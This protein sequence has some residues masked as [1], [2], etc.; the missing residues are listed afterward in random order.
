MKRFQRHRPLPRLS[1]GVWGLL[2]VLLVLLGVAAPLLTN[3]RAQT[4]PPAGRPVVVV[5]IRDEIDLGLAPFLARAL[6]SAQQQNARAVVL[7]ISTPGGRLDAVLQM[8]ASL[9]NSPVRTVAFVNRE[10]FSAGALIAI[11]AQ[12]IYLA[13]G[14]V[15]GA[16][17]PVTGAGVAADPKT[18]SAV[19]STFRATAELRGRDPTVAEAMVDPAIAIPGLVS[20]GQLLTLTTA[21]AERVGYASGVVADRAALLRAAGLSG[22]PVN[23]ARVSLAENVVRFLTNPVV[24][25]LLTSLGFVLILADVYSG[26]FG[27]IGS[28][29]VGLF[30]LFFWGH[31]LAGLAGW[32]GVVLAVLGLVLIGVEVFVVPGLGVAGLLGA[33]ALLG[34]L[35]LSLVGGEI[36]TT[37]DFTRAGSTLLGTLILMV[38]GSALLLRFLPRAARVQGMILRSQV[39]VA[40]NRTVAR[41]A[42]TRNFSPRWR[43]LEGDRLEAHSRTY[44]EGAAEP[45]EARSFTGAT[46]V[47]L[48]DLRPGGIASID[49]E[50]V[51]VVSRGEYI[52]AGER[53]E[54]IADEGYRRVVRR[55]QGKEE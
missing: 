35:F 46:G 34:G 24:A 40:D 49:G 36:V 31:F 26:G 44:A 42:P 47:A 25:S 54:V 1:F 51:D 48:S 6:Q 16:A 10:A 28:V 13:P 9:L 33:A 21:Q 37:Q 41:S 17:T 4:S 15:L 45:A 53:V 22:A 14:A 11:A 18:V 12:E 23:E 3:A 8:R 20:A 55:P 39:G 29:G 30:A 27:A 5:P 19:R 43:W 7:E 38:A 50:R 32:E 52:G 2:G